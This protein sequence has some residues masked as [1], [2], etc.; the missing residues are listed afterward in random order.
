MFRLLI[1][2]LLSVVVAS[3]INNHEQRPAIFSFLNVKKNAQNKIQSF[4]HKVS[5]NDVRTVIER[6]PKATVAS[7]KASTLSFCSSAVV[8]VPVGLV[9][10]LNKVRPIDAWL[11]R[12]AMTGVEWAK[13]GAYFVVSLSRQSQF[14]HP[15][16]LCVGGIIRENYEL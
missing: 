2:L 8:L 14:S 12:G 4:H 15:L 10:N 16:L 11:K 7:L 5:A 6:L 3:A 1:I 9:M 13:V